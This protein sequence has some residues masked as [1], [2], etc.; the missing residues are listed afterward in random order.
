MIS[1]G[2]VIGAL[3][4]A[5]VVI[6]AL[7][8]VAYRKVVPTNMVHIVQSGKATTSYGRGNANGNIYYAWPSWIPV[9]GISVIE[10]PESI[11]KVQLEAYQAYDHARLPFM[12]DVVAFFR[13]SD[14]GTAAQR[15]ASFTELNH[16][17]HSVLQ[18]SVRRILAT[19]TLEHIMESR[20][21]LSIQFTS[22]VEDQIKEWGVIPAKSIEFMDIHDTTNSVVIQNIMDKEKS[23]IDRES[24]I[25][26]ADNEKQAELY[27][28]DAKRT[29]DVQRQDALQQVG[30][31]TAEKDKI[32]GIATEVA[33]QEIQEQAKLTAEKQMAVVR[34]EE[35]RRAEI[36][37]A[38]TITAAQASRDTHV[39]KAEGDKQALILRADGDLQTTL[40]QAEGIKALGQSN[41]NAQE[42]LLMAPVTAQ[43]TLAKEIGSN[44]EYQQYLVTVEQISANK[45]VGIE[46]AKAISNADIKIIGGDSN[47]ASSVS[48]VTD[49]FSAAGGLKVASMLSAVAATPAGAAIGEAITDAL[50]K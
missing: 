39:L 50:N 8:A 9:I 14:S 12:V 42:L 48:K 31:R 22:E 37:K 27:E 1:L 11:F 3:L 36:N 23:R 33:T 26:V 10:F 16:Q 5:L 19:N 41:A 24:R 47:I 45:E 6:I 46:M 44:T 20:S 34:V 35:E 30:T 25:A 7:V 49:M 32:V 18:G 15:V 29:V 38:V 40:K 43:I 17:L 2:L 28:I 21:E 4:F 13:V